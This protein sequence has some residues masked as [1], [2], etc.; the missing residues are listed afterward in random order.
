MLKYENKLFNISKG[1][2][3]WWWEQSKEQ[4][5]NSE[6]EKLSTI[7]FIII[8]RRRRKKVDIAL[9]YIVYWFSFSAVAEKCLSS[10]QSV[11][12]NQGEMCV[13]IQ[14]CFALYPTLIPHIHS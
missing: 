12:G 11:E 14:F 6:R 4:Q 9:H 3:K 8:V 2:E 10:T 5:T 1:K 13:H 7:L